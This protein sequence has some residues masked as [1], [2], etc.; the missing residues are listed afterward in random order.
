MSQENKKISNWL[1]FDDGRKKPQSQT[2]KL[3]PLLKKK[4]NYSKLEEDEESEKRARKKHRLCEDPEL[5]QSP[6]S[7]TYIIKEWD[8]IKRKNG[9]GGEK[10]T[11]SFSKSEVAL[12][13]IAASFVEITPQARARL[14][15]IPNRIGPFACKLCKVVYKDAFELAMHNCPRVVNIEYK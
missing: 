14:E 3:P 2:S 13:S 15:K 5:T 12:N 9:G 11:T 10:V 8:N 1:I 7:G 4:L 6:V